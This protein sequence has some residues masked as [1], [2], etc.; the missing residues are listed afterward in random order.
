M[1][2]NIL[3]DNRCSNDKKDLVDQKF[4]D[5]WHYS[6]CRNITN[7][8]FM[9]FEDLSL[10]K[11]WLCW[12]EMWLENAVRTWVAP[13]TITKIYTSYPHLR[14][15][16]VNHN[17]SRAIVKQNSLK[18]NSNGTYLSQMD[19]VDYCNIWLVLRWCW[20]PPSFWSLSPT[21]LIATKFGV[22][23]SLHLAA[24]ILK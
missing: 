17:S 19:S 10:K 20:W 8:I 23:A 9:I 5:C 6:I 3:N 16:S 7:L 11:W 1:P 14:P 21:L 24:N 15:E 2:W 22:K 12:C 13:T 4:K 18:N